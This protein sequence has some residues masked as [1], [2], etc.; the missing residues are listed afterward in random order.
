VCSV[1]CAAVVRV[2]ARDGIKA[3][4]HVPH[5]H[6]AM[7]DQRTPVTGV[8]ALSLLAHGPGCSVAGSTVHSF[9]LPN[10]N[11]TESLILCGAISAIVC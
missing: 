11:T 10:T 6:A 1:D 7:K 9:A 8:S 4:A 3:A 2:C 5:R